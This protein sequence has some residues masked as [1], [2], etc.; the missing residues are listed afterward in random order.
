MTDRRLDLV[1]LLRDAPKGA[2]LV[3]LKA[4][5][6]P[7]VEYVWFLVKGNRRIDLRDWHDQGRPPIEAWSS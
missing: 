2:E 4:G 3:R 6:F 5:E 1:D 7:A